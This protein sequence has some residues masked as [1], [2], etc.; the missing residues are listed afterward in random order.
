MDR[1]W[2]GGEDEM[3]GRKRGSGN[4]NWYDEKNGFKKNLKKQK[5]S[6]VKLAV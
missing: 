4:W 5:A 3:N 1:E 6:K 2:G